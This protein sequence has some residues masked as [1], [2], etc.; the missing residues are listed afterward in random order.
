MDAFGTNVVY[1]YG[2]YPEQSNPINGIQGPGVVRDDDNIVHPVPD[3]ISPEIDITDEQ[4]DIVRDF[5]IQADRGTYALNGTGTY[6]PLGIGPEVFQPDPNGTYN[7]A[8]FVVNALQEAGIT[9]TM[10]TVGIFPWWLPGAYRRVPDLPSVWD[11]EGWGQV[12][13]YGLEPEGISGGFLGGA[14]TRRLP[15]DPLAIDLDGDGIE[16]VGVGT[17]PILFDHNADGIRTGTGWVTGD[18]AWL[19]LDRTRGVTQTRGHK[20]GVKSQI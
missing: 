18:D 2:Y 3:R 14:R 13:P 9:T 5:A 4:A 8:S 20:R 10:P 12:D 15:R 7:C 6:L 19:A 16:T 11:A 1:S 17:N